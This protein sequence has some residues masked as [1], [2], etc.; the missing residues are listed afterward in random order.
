MNNKGFTVIEVLVALAIFVLMMSVL[1]TMLPSL[2]QTNTA[3]RDQQRV[4]LA[5]RSY[6][7]A[8]RSA[9]AVN[10]NADPRAIAVPNTGDGLSCPTKTVQTTLQYT[11][12]SPTGSA[13]TTDVLKRVSLGCTLN[14]RDYSFVLDITQ[15]NL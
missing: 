8:V 3:A 15:A 11:A 7:E 9:M 10:F 12:V 5:A 2:A 1:L 14:N 4:T 13:S 6:F